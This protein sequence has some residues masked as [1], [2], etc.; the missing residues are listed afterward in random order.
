MIDGAALFYTTQQPATL[1]ALRHYALHLLFMQPTSATSEG[2]LGRNPFPQSSKPNTL[3]RD[4]I[5]VPAGWDS[6]G[7]IQILRDNFEY[8]TWSDAWEREIDPEKQNESQGP[9]AKQ[10]FET[11]IGGNQGPQ[12]SRELVQSFDLADMS[13]RK[14]HSSL[15][16][17]Q[18]Q[19]RIS[20][21]SIG[22]TTRRN[23]T[24]IL[25]HLSVICRI[26]WERMPMLE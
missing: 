12:V 8:K 13:H 7:K 9:G 4:R 17:C 3:D 26:I 2:T 18:S 24:E 10:L 14:F 11:L 16:Y 19:N 5:F 1:A 23:L 22:M 21:R 20:Y 15:W 6:W 25:E